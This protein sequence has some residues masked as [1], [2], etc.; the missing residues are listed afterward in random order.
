MN[1]KK[2]IALLFGGQSSE[3]E[4]SCVSGATVAGAIDREKYD[5][6]LI[7]I[8]KEGR[9]LKANSVEEI[10]SGAW[11][12]SA[13][14][15]ALL[16]DATLKSVLVR[17][18]NGCRLLPVDVI[19]PVLHGLYGEDGCPQAIAELAQ[20]P[21]VGCGVLS[22]A[23]TMDKALTK[24]VLSR[25]GI[26]QTAFRAF[27]REELDDFAPVAADVEAKIGYPAFVKPANA[28]S[29]CGISRVSSREELRDAL[30][31]AASQDCKVIVEAEVRGRELECALLG[32]WN[33]ETA[34]VGE[35]LSAAAFYDYDAK[36]KNPASKTV[37]DPRLPAGKSE[38]ICAMAV[39]VYRALDCRG[40]ARADFFLEEGTNRVV[41]NEINT[42]PGFTSISMYPK[43]WEAAGLSLEDLVQR[44]ID[45]AAVTAHF[46]QP[47][48]LR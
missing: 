22:S 43:L 8:T 21:Y 39:K 10:R 25:L 36:Y 34:G 19:F 26:P 35:I 20:I 7:G 30:K 18:E 48:A 4:V 42:I 46:A 12:N 31:L 33:A 17:S 1:H 3:H 15:A 44:L 6:L 27:R 5:L 28:G 29:S 38:E 32:G 11:R 14:E 37:I 24:A 13:T 16:P 2:R 41:F 45:S 40:L 23:L 47:P 9:W